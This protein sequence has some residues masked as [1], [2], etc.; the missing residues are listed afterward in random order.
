MKKYLKW[1]GEGIL[2][3]IAAYLICKLIEILLIRVVPALILF[4]F[5]G[6]AAILAVVAFYVYHN[7]GGE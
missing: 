7:K 4:I 6:I 3:I 5:V 2:A 1:F